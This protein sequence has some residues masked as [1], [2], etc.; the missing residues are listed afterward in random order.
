[1]ET[2]GKKLVD[3][4]KSATDARPE[5]IFK[6]PEQRKELLAALRKLTLKLEDPHE[7]IVRMIFQPHENAAIRIAIDLNLFVLVGKAENGVTAEELEQLTGAE[8][9]LLA[10][11]VEGATRHLFDESAV[12]LSQ[13]PEFLQ[14]TKYENP[15]DTKNGPFQHAFKTKSKMWEY[16]SERPSRLNAFN[17]FMEGQRVGRTQ[18]YRG[19]P[20]EESLSDESNDL[21]TVLMVDVGGGRGHDLEAFKAAFPQL[22]GKAIVQDLPFTIDDIKHL[23]PEVEAMKHNFFDPQPVKGAKSY[24][25]RNIF[26]DWPDKDARVILQHT[27]DA[28]KKGYSRILINEWVL[29]DTNSSV[30]STLM[31]INMMCLFA[32]TERT[33]SHWDALLGS[34]GLKIVKVWDLGPDTESLIEAVLA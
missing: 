23:A 1:M 20:V 12:S 17:D 24:Y 29:S 13:L 11:P 7:A 25:F 2:D 6:K 9:A 16:I 14:Q 31:D 19:F 32:G 27:A 15:V 5:E 33:R 18:W 34:A 26:H 10:P 30:L 28:M 21:D 4:V 3:L 22:P 8:R